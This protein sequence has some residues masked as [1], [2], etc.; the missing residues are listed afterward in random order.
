[1]IIKLTPKGEEY[2]KQIEAKEKKDKMCLSWIM[3]C[4]GEGN[5]YQH[6][7]EGIGKY[8]ET[9]A[10]YSLNNNV[11]NYHDMHLC[12]VRVISESK[13]SW[14]NKEKPLQIKI[15]GSHLPINVLIS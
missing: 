13:L 11:K 4:S 3:F 14:L 5:S 8:K 10:N 12:K 6:E 2:I 1:D 9:Y 15:I 7:C